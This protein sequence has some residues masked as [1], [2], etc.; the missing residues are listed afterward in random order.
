M[1]TQKL[2]EFIGNVHL[3]YLTLLPAAAGLFLINILQ[4]STFWI[5]MIFILGTGIVGMYL[6]FTV[7]RVQ[8]SN[9]IS[10]NLLLLLDAP[11][12]VF[13]HLFLSV[14]CPQLLLELVLIEMSAMLLPFAF[15]ALTQSAH[16]TKRI[17]SL[18][19][20]GGLFAGTM[21]VLL[22]ISRFF[23]AIDLV[24]FGGLAI[25]I[26][27]STALNHRAQQSV[28]PHSN[29]TLI[30]ALGTMAWMLAFFLGAAF[31]V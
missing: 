16:M 25:A 3:A 22:L 6:L 30:I 12:L 2:A 7:S 29:E 24:H 17:L 21:L 4:P 26:V 27:I 9:R 1:N 14:S 5:W 11:V 20:I 31:L 10:S 8:I 18:I 23:G 15:L 19:F 28:R 13:I